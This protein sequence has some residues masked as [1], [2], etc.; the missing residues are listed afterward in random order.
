[1]ETVKAFEQLRA[2]G[3]IKRWGVSNFDVEDMEDLWSIENGTNAP[4]ARFSTIWK[5]GKLN[6][7]S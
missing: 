2:A 1:L 6:P 5:T 7:F 4:P 3:K